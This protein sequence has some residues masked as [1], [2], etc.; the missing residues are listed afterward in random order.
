MIA[1]FARAV[2]RVHPPHRIRRSCPLRAPDLQRPAVL[3]AYANQAGFVQV[4]VLPIE[5]E[6][7]RF[8]RLTPG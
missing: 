1:T 3:R 6:M 4:D 8:Y 7:W 5:N 2:R